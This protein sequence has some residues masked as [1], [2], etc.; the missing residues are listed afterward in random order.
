[1]AGVIICMGRNLQPIGI[2]PVGL[3]RVGGKSRPHVFVGSNGDE[4]FIMLRGSKSCSNQGAVDEALTGSGLNSSKTL[5]MLRK[6]ASIS[7][8]IE[9][10]K[11][12]KMAMKVQVQKK[13][14]KIKNLR[15]K[16]LRLKKRV[17]DMDEDQVQLMLDLWKEEKE[18]KDVKGAKGGA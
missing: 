2:K 10:A 11:K 13:A 3:D 6:G 7:S 12:D 1:M 5:T 14:S 9:E 18:R 8:Q 4:N 15:A 16:R 17:K